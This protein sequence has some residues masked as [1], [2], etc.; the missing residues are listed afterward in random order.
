MNYKTKLIDKKI[1][2]G[3][4]TNPDGMVGLLEYRPTDDGGETPIMMLW[5]KWIFLILSG[6]KNSFLYS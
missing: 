1:F 5:V 2:L 4:S 3:E 6:T